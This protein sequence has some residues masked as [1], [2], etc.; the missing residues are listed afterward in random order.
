MII[1]DGLYSFISVIL[2]SASL[3]VCKVI[4]VKDNEDFPFGK[5]V[6][7]PLVVSI[8]SIILIIMCLLSLYDAI[9]A[10][11]L[12][13]NSVNTSSAIVYA[14]VSTL[15]SFIFYDRIKKAG[16]KINSELIDAESIQWL[17]DGILSATVLFGFILSAIIS[18]TAFS[19]ITKYI[20]PTMVIITSILF[21]KAP[22]KIFINSFKE[23]IGVR[24]PERIS[25]EVEKQV[26]VIKNEYNFI[27]AVTR[28]LKIGRSVKIEVNFIIGENNQLI[29]KEEEEIIKN[30]LYI[31]IDSENYF[32]DMQI[33][34]T[35]NKNNLITA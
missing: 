26:E 29:T 14:I 27:Q 18:K 34:F 20:D 9:N 5:Y 35:T 3:V 13:G 21:L 25:V 2:S 7:E 17:M 16:K 8:N 28:V 33:I 30:E 12:G 11:L 24:V 32:K 22:L 31:G 10:L 15:G 6:L 1:F 19:F 4:E 23:V